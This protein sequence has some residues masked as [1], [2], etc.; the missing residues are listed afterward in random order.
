MDEEDCRQAQ[1][2]IS[3]ACRKSSW[4]L[5]TGVKAAPN[6]A[7][8]VGPVIANAV[9]GGKFENINP[10]HFPQNEAPTLSP[11]V[12]VVGVGLVLGSSRMPNK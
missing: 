3:G 8:P 10:K 9:A 4:S 7:L 2:D 6:S 12:A 5:M 11:H 1:L